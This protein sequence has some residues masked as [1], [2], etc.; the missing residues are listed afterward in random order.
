MKI[1]K[2]FLIACL[3]TL[4]AQA[5]KKYELASP[6]GKLKTNITAGKQ[7]TYDIVFNGQQVI[8]AAPISITLENGEVWGE[9]DKPTSA[10]RKSVSEKVASPFYRA[11]EMED[12]YH[13]LVLSFKGNWSVEFRAYND[14]IAYRFVSKS[15]KPFNIANEEVNFQFNSDAKGACF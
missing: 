1:F 14:G 8:A 2:L 3:F 12:N 10:K 15:K 13:Q 11:A 5:Q 4:T 6:D 9:N 7:L